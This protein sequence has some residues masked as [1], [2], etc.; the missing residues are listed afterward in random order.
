MVLKDGLARLA[1]LASFGV[2]RTAS[3]RTVHERLFL[4][5]SDHWSAAEEVSEAVLLKAKNDPEERKA[6]G[7]MLANIAFTPG[8]MSGT[9]ISPPAGRSSCSIVSWFRSHS[10]TA[11][12][13]GA[14][15]SV[16]SLSRT[17][18][19]STRAFPAHATLRDLADL[20]HATGNT[21]Q[22]PFL[23]PF[24][25]LVYDTMGLEEINVE[26]IVSAA[27]EIKRVVAR[28]AFR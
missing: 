17:L 10:C 7:L 16:G 15:V 3:S 2:C 13:I 23:E 5:S 22:P 1:A 19:A 11:T 26:E 24:G 21:E 28:T 20:V 27:E 12:H 18:G 6:H 8:L 4:S 9:P 25:Q 14:R